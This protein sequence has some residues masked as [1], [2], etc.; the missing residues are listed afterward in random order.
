M[1]FLNKLKNVFRILYSEAEKKTNSKEEFPKVGFLTFDKI[2]AIENELDI[3]MSNPSIYEQAFSHRS[4]LQV[5]PEQNLTS[6]ERL[7]FLG[8]AILGAVTSDYLFRSNPDLP[9]GELTKIRSWLVNKNSLAVVAEKLNFDKYLMLSFSASKSLESGSKSILADALESI[10]AAI[11]LD[12][13]FLEAQKF[14][15]LKILPILMNK[16][17]MVDTNYKSI[18]LEYVQSIGYSAPKYVVTD[19]KGPDHL[20]EFTVSVIVDDEDWGVGTGKSKKEAEQLAAQNAIEKKNIR[21][22]LNN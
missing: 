20:K 19:E 22:E 21:T 8:D 17:I 16:S 10:I 11:F 15:I 13:G 3:K 7:E 9:E 2:K 12:K 14:I 18:L 4:Y 5:V 6:N 1:L